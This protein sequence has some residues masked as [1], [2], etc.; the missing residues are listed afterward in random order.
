MRRSLATTVCLGILS[1]GCGTELAAQDTD[2]KHFGF[3]T[4]ASVDVMVFYD[5]RSTRRLPGGTLQVWTKGLSAKEI[6]DT[7]LGESAMERLIWRNINGYEPPLARVQKLNPDQ[8]LDVMIFEEIA[9]TGSIET[10]VRTLHEIDC[11]G[12]MT[13]TLSAYMKIAGKPV[14]SDRAEEWGHIPPETAVAALATLL[15]S[16]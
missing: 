2:W 5:T 10:M 12:K 4:V 6:T 9:N 11:S 8:I 13:R 16:G 14:T 7:K 3:I 15:C 1:L